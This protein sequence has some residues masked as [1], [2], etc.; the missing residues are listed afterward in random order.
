MIGSQNGLTS[1]FSLGSTEAGKLGSPRSARKGAR[2]IEQQSRIPKPLESLSQPEAAGTQPG[3]QSGNSYQQG[4]GIAGVFTTRAADLNRLF[5]AQLPAQE[6]SG[7]GSGAGTGNRH[8]QELQGMKANIG[9]SFQASLGS[10]TSTA[11]ATAQTTTSIPQI[12]GGFSLGACRIYL[13]IWICRVC[14]H[15]IRSAG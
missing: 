15:A 1:G 7:S 11:G 2:R 4:G 14:I 13:Q 10:G 8:Q 9:A 12:F 6:T 3:L 5:T